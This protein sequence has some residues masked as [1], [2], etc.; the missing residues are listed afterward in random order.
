VTHT[1]TELRELMESYRRRSQSEPATPIA[2]AYAEA[3]DDLEEIIAGQS[4]PRLID[5]RPSR[6]PA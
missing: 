1:I 5:A 4:C 6:Q 3:A 2:A